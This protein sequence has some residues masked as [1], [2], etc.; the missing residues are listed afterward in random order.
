MLIFAKD[1]TQRNYQ[2]SREDRDPGLRTYMD[3]QRSLFPYTVVRAGLDLAYKELDDIL[4]YVDNDYQPPPNSSRTDYPADITQWYG[5]RFP[6]TAAFL[7]MEE[8]HFALVVLVRAMDSFRTEETPNSFHLAVL[9]DCAHNI[10]QVYNTLLQ[11]SS[12]RAR[13]IHLSNGIPVSFDDFINNYWPQLDFMVL[14]KPD[15]PHAPHMGRNRKIEDAIKNWLADG[16]EPPTAFQKAADQFGL[17]ET[18]LALLRRDPV[19][20]AFLEIQSR[21]QS[22]DTFKW[23]YEEV[24]DY[25]RTEKIPLIDR[26]YQLN[27]EYAKKTGWRPHS[28]AREMGP[29]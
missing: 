10:V 7:K 11:Q 23:L 13:D 12:E 20:T 4:L 6:W 5:S 16:E 26:E 1:I 9:Y 18:T 17:G 2:H 25:P 21:L 27:F 28:E 24:R 8:M 3:Y 19:K 29:I 22:D 14:S 15:F